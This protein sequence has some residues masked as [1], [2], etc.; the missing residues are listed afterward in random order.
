MRQV[1]RQPDASLQVEVEALDRVR[2]DELMQQE[3]CML[4]PVEDVPEKPENGREATAMMRHLAE[5]FSQY[6]GLNNKVPQ[7]APE[8]IR[9]AR[10]TGYMADL[11][12]AHLVSDVHERQRVL[13]MINQAERLQHMASV[14]TNEIDVLETD[15][16]VRN[17]VRASIDKNQR[18]FYLREQ[19]KAIHD[20]LG[21]EGGNE[22]AELR[23]RAEKKGLPEEILPAMLKE[24]E[25]AGAD[26]LRLARKHR[27]AQLHRLGA[28]P[29][30]D[31]A[32]SRPY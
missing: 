6:A 8:H 29:P 15:Q 12:A 21:G 16:R 19:L 28:G 23:E 25:Q 2:I 32:H 30:L 20:E 18:E 5:L 13:E 9:A 22:I 7:D 14:L 31:R 27:A 26:A 24:A 10:N 17:K 4:A 1:R 11:L 3:P